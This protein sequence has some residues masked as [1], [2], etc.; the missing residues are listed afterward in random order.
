MSFLY[1]TSP[2][3]FDPTWAQVFP[4]IFLIKIETLLLFRNKAVRLER[5]RERSCVT[6]GF[7]LIEK[8]DLH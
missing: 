5:E 8:I 1:D 6:L 3:S 2:V 4:G 7:L